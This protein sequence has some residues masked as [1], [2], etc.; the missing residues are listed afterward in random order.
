MDTKSSVTPVKILLIDDEPPSRKMM[1]NDILKNSPDLQV[2]AEAKSSQ[3]A[4]DHLQKQDF[5]LI[6]MDYV[7]I[8]FSYFVDGPDLTRSI[9]KQYPEIKIVFWSIYN[10]PLTKKRALEAGANGYF[11]KETE[12]EIIIAEIRKIMGLPST[13]LEVPDS[14]MD[15][16]TIR[17]G[18]VF[19]LVGEAK[20]SK[21][22]NVIFWVNEQIE[23]F[24]IEKRLNI[25]LKK[26]SREET[27]YA[28][29]AAESFR[30]DIRY[31]GYL[32]KRECTKNLAV[33]YSP[34]VLISL[35]NDG[36]S[37]TFAEL[38]QWIQKRYEDEQEKTYI[39]SLLTEFYT[40]QFSR[41]RKEAKECAEKNLQEYLK[42]KKYE[43]NCNNESTDPVTLSGWVK[44]CPDKHEF[45]ALAEWIESKNSYKEKQNIYYEMQVWIN[46][47][48]INFYIEDF[49]KKDP[50]DASK[51]DLEEAEGHL[52]D[53]RSK[54]YKYKNE[55]YIERLE[56]ADVRDL[57]LKDLDSWIEKQIKNKE[58]NNNVS[59]E[60]EA[61]QYKDADDYDGEIKEITETEIDPV[62]R[63]DKI[64]RD[65]LNLGKK[66]NLNHSEL[67]RASQIFFGSPGVEQ[68][69]IA[70]Q[71]L[72]SF[73][74]YQ[75]FL[76]S[77]END[78]SPDI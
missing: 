60:E 28:K 68:A 51:D 40:K 77:G 1:R 61:K 37:K 46:D 11:A 17:E 69:R 44:T 53:I 32:F 59:F 70:Q 23:S 58:S 13:Q 6:I 16:L 75:T 36:M 48:I 39:K 43:K 25:D 62:I 47:Q 50:N 63:N 35:T 22:I 14:I 64:N 65:L 57:K 71:L 55:S 3:E 31:S 38:N 29:K 30:K 26:V 45:K 67:I 56:R 5:D 24:Y 27:S 72:D 19:K 54:G 49:L 34:E 4:L 8:D 74:A 76:N 78:E 15:K 42:Y 12:P 10:Y 52:K 7:L 73:S 21:E 20:S 41:P 18:E 66:L 2:I 33:R 9:R